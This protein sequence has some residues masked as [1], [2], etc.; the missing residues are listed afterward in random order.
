MA[1]VASVTV[2]PQM[3]TCSRVVSS[4]RHPSHLNPSGLPGREGPVGKEEDEYSVVPTLWAPVLA[5][6]TGFS[7]RPAT[8]LHMRSSGHGC[9][10]ASYMSPLAAL[11]C[12][13]TANSQQAAPTPAGQHSVEKQLSRAIAK[14]LIWGRSHFW[15]NSFTGWTGQAPYHQSST[16]LSEKRL[17]PKPY[18]LSSLTVSQCCGGAAT[19]AAGCAIAGAQLKC[20]A[21]ISPIPN[22]PW[23]LKKCNFSAFVYK[24]FYL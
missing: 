7:C 15:G 14:S 2:K 23:A 17:S 19:G 9:A 6:G 12:T 4:G 5:A 13:D 22:T 16:L 8:Q 3:K 20:I 18:T 21:C 10:D 1:W 24:P 11:V